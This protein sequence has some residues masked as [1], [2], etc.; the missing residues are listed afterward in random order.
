M[1]IGDGKASVADDT[2]AETV[3]PLELASV[4]KRPSGIT[5]GFGGDE[6]SSKS[7]GVEKKGNR[8]SWHF[9]STTTTH[10]SF[11]PYS[12]YSPSTLLNIRQQPTSNSN[13]KT[14][15]VLITSVSPSTTSIRPPPLTSIDLQSKL[16]DLSESVEYSP[17]KGWLFCEKIDCRTPSNSQP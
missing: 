5:G 9:D 4:R 15:H 11:Y 12:T 17:A 3:D 13:Y 14:D 7:N 6:V 1:P 10:P 2:A 8:V 16:V